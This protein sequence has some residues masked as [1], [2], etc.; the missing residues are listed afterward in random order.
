MT[1]SIIVRWGAYAGIASFVLAVSALIGFLASVGSGSISEAA[2]SIGFY[3]AG[4]SALG[5]IV[6][7]VPALVALYFRQR[8]RISA[9]GAAAFFVALVGTVLAAGGQWTYVFVVPYIADEVP[10]LVN[11]SSGILLAG[12]FLS[13][14][15]L[16]IGWVLFGV[17]T[18]RARVFPRWVCVLLIAGS[19]LAIVPMPSRTI[20]L[21]LAVAVLG[22]R[23]LGPERE[24]ASS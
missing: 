11:E 5:S 8:D 9:G 6:C 1:Q 12:F 10:E 14:A 4:G 23:M 22:A 21:A 19:A 20:I 7:L 2:G 3:F 13:S 17:A 18:L 15:V 16:V 24:V